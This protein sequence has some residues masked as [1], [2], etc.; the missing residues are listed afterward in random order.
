MDRGLRRGFVPVFAVILTALAGYVDAAGYIRYMQIFAANMSGNHIRLGMSLVRGRYEDALLRLLP[1]MTFAAGAVTSEVVVR[2]VE[3]ERRLRAVSAVWGLEVLCLCG[4]MLV[5]CLEKGRAGAADY[6]G[7]GLLAFAMGLQ[8]TSLRRA[9][10]SSVYTTHVTGSL[11]RACMH[12]AD[13]L[14]RHLPLARR[15]GIR[16]GPRRRVSGLLMH[17]AIPVVYVGGAAGGAALWNCG[18]CRVFW[19]PAGVL[20]VLAIV[21]GGWW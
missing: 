14:S 13:Y 15:K 21:I 18:S 20:G 11:T 19:L 6:V 1:I 12:L 10:G 16:G 9:G 5:D 17:W 8:N 7:L 2:L 4:T 3:R